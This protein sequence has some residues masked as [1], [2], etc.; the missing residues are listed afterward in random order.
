MAT[1]HYK[2]DWVLLNHP[3]FRSSA[4]QMRVPTPLQRPVMYKNVP[5][6]RSMAPGY[7]DEEGTYRMYVNRRSVAPGHKFENPHAEGVREQENTDRIFKNLFE[8]VRKDTKFGSS[9]G[10]PQVQTQHTTSVHTAPR[11]VQ[12]SVGGYTSSGIPQRPRATQVSAGASTPSM[13]D[14]TPIPV[15]N[16]RHRNEDVTSRKKRIIEQIPKFVEGVGTSGRSRSGK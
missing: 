6:P 9:A 7:L 15:R 16:K 4:G 14:P 13:S 11:A 3:E 5:G 1:A 8:D 10:S 2:K 12:G